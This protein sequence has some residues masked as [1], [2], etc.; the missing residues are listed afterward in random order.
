M[1]CLTIAKVHI[2]YIRLFTDMKPGGLDFA[3]TIM[4]LTQRLTSFSCSLYDGLCVDDR[5]LTPVRRKQAIRTQPTF[6]EFFS[7]T[8]HFPG[9]LAGPMVFYNDYMSIFETQQSYKPKKSLAVS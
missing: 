2:T 5:K 3:A 7:Y 4:V 9:I 8:F 6:A 1:G